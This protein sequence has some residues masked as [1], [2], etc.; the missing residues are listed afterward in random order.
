MV[1][2]EQHRWSNVATERPIWAV[3]GLLADPPN[4]EENRDSEDDA[5]KK[6]EGA[7]VVAG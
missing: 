3:V 2:K 1:S 4:V 5:G 6:S 7:E